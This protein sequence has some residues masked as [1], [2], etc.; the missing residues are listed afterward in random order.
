MPALQEALSAERLAEDLRERRRQQ[1]GRRHKLQSAV[2][3]AS[4]G[5]NIY[6]YIYT[7]T[8]SLPRT[9]G[10]GDSQRR[11]RVERLDVG[12]QDVLPAVEPVQ[13]A[14]WPSPRNHGAAT[15]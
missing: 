3:G 6:T 12:L 15:Q 9:S 7:Y 2:E 4:L 11:R 13:M 14:V 10:G 8:H 1:T 5:C